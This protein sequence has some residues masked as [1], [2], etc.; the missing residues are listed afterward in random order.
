MRR[1]L[2]TILHQNYAQQA[3]SYAYLSLYL[4]LVI[5]LIISRVYGLNVHQLIVA[6]CHSY[7]PRDSD[8]EKNIQHR[9][10]CVPK[11]TSEAMF[12]VVLDRS[13]LIT[14]IVDNLVWKPCFNVGNQNR[15]IYLQSP[16]NTYTPLQNLHNTTTINHRGTTTH[17]FTF[18]NTSLTIFQLTFQYIQHCVRHCRSLW[19]GWHSVEYFTKEH[20]VCVLQ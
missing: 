13:I 1:K 4:I 16:I 2:S 18:L 10:G 17:F 15:T 7:E 5:V 6:M 14:T 8:C 9:L 19:T 20:H 11:E 12:C 3:I